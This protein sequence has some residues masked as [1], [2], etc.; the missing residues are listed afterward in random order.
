MI[1]NNTVMSV[2]GNF[3][4]QSITAGIDNAA[5]AHIM[6]VLSGIY[7]NIHEAIIREYAVNAL[8]AQ[9]VI[10][11]KAPIEVKL[12]GRL[13]SSLSIKDH[14]IGLSV[15]DLRRIYSQYGVSTKRESND[16][17]GCIGIGGKSAWAYTH[18]FSMIAVKDNVKTTALLTKD[19]QG[20]GR[21]DV[22]EVVNTNEPSG[23]EIIVPVNSSD[24][25]QF[26]KAAT[27]VFS[28]WPAGTVL[29]N[30]E[31][32]SPFNYEIKLSD[33]IYIPDNYYGRGYGTVVMGG[34]PY[35]V[36]SSQG[37]PFGAIVFAEMG[38]VSFAPSREALNY[39]ASTI[40]F[41]ENKRAEINAK[42]AE[43]ISVK[44]AACSTYHEAAVEAAN[45]EHYHVPI[46][47]RG[48]AIPSR[49]HYHY[50]D[51]DG[52][53]YG[54]SR[55]TRSA[56]DGS[57]FITG[58]TG[59]KVSKQQRAKIMIATAGATASIL[60]DDTKAK[61]LDNCKI[62]SWNEIVKQK[63]ELETKKQNTW[64]VLGVYGGV[65]EKESL[66]DKLVYVNA[67]DKPSKDVRE[68]FYHEHPDYQIVVKR[69]NYAQQ[70]EAQFPHVQSLRGFALAEAKRIQQENDAKS[71]YDYGV[72][73]Y[74]Q[75]LDGIKIDDPDLADHVARS[76]DRMD[77]FRDYAGRWVRL[78]LGHSA[79]SNPVQINPL[80]GYPMIL[81]V[82]RWRLDEKHAELYINAVY[83]YNKESK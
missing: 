71:D 75:A 11:V 35:P 12:P 76:V 79:F 81:G 23:V 39:N 63:V 55:W 40:E 21:I 64:G 42:L 15:D 66:G 32:P 20:V 41:L 6:N 26:E 58:F 56:Q 43:S 48:E 45:Y 31:K 33:T 37:L 17:T 14:G 1:P 25:W 44:I 60:V 83:N 30:G 13:D 24:Q 72:L 3:N 10:G 34:V 61:W 80:A 70:F 51:A 46:T 28:Y 2:S 38:D 47:Y 62:F 8:D 27:K 5:L 52:A 7:S 73:A 78:M 82:S 59:K 67:D 29:V 57:Y 18:S 65:S 9:R 50:V 22:M 77:V 16:V 36:D 69:K 74:L 49:V 53:E 54:M 68:A 4:G 19:Q